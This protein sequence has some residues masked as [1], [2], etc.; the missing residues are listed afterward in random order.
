LEHR[1]DSQVSTDRNGDRSLLAD[2]MGHINLGS[3]LGQITARV[4]MSEAIITIVA[5]NSGT[6]VSDRFTNVIRARVGA[7]YVLAG[8]DCTGGRVA[9]YEANGGFILG[10]DATITG[11]LPRLIAALCRQRQ[12]SAYFKPNSR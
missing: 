2:E 1:L 11:L 4:V 3:I 6:E 9:E 5:S 12:D 10:F 7:P 8:V